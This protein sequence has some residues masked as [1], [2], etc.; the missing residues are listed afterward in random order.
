MV[1]KDIEAIATDIVDCAIKVHR[2][3]G[4]GLLESAYQHC[5]AHEL[6]KRHRKVLMEVMLPIVYDGQ[7]LDAGYRIDMLID[8]LVIIENK[9][10]ENFLPIHMAQL[11]TY[12]KLYDRNVG[13]LLNWNV[14]LMKHGIKRVVHNY[15]SSSPYPTK[16][17]QKSF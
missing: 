5:I 12:L 7:R 3:L 6:K 9:T 2:E 16:K 4:P 8:D 14:K 15:S 11:T 17:K 10:V 1:K 13:F